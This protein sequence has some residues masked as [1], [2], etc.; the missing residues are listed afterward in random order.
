[1]DDE[2]DPDHE[3]VNSVL[4]QESSEL[5]R[6]LSCQ[7]P[8]V[9]ME[10]WEK[11][12][13]ASTAAPLCVEA[14]LEYFKEASAAKCRQFLQRVCL[15]CENM[16]MHL[17][18]RLMSVAGCAIS[19]CEDP[20]VPDRNASP[21]PLEQQL[22]KRPRIDHWEQNI[23]AV[24]RS[25]LTRFERLTQRLVREVQ[26]ENVWVG[27]RTANRGRDRPDQ[28][29]GSADRGSRTPEPD[30]YFGCLESRLTLESFF[31]GCVGKVTVLVGRAGSGKT[32]LMSCLGQQW[33]NGL[34]PI[35]SSYLFVLLEF[36]QLNLL[37]RPLTLSELLFQHHLPPA[38][39]D[40]EKRAVMDYLLSNP[41]QSCWVLDGYD[42]FHCK[43]GG[44][45][46]PLDSETPRPVADLVSGLL[47]RQL[48][49]GCTVLL[50]CRVRDVVDL[51]GVV[52]KVGQL[53]GWDQ[54][55]IEEYVDDF[56]GGKA[57]GVQAADLLRSSRHLLAMSSLPAL[58]NIC[59][60]CLEHLL[61]EGRDAG[62]TQEERGTAKAAETGGAGRDEDSRGR[63]RSLRG[64]GKREDTI[65]DG[66]NGGVH[67]PPSP[68]RLPST[69]TQVYLTALSAFLS[70]SP[71]EGGRD[72]RSTRFT[73][74]AASLG[75]YRSEL[76]EL[77]RLTWSGLEQSR[78][79][80]MEEDVPPGVL[81]F[82]LR[83]GLLSQ[84]EVRCQDGTP[85]NA[86]SFVH[87]TLQEFLAA[88]RIMTSNDVS[89]TQLRKR[90]SLKTRWMTK[91]DQRTVFT[92]SLYL[93]V[94]GLASP[95][96][97]AALVQLARASCGPG[98]QS[99][100]EKRQALVLKL[101]KGLCH[102]NNLTGPKLLE[103]CH[104]V[105]E[106][107]D[108]QLAKEVVGSRPVLELRKIW[109]LPND[110]DALAFV[111]NSGGDN[112]VGLDFGA[113]S[114]ELDCLDVLPRCQ[115]IH[116]LSFRS[117][118]YDDKFA[119]KLSSVLP[120]FA[121]LRKLEFFGT[122]L[123]AAGAASLASGLQNCL[124]ITEINL[125]DNNLKDEGIE[126]VAEIFNKL[127]TLA[128]V[129]LGRNNT[130]LKALDCLVEKMSSCSNI[131]HVHADGMKEVTVTFYTNHK[132][133][134]EPTI[135]LLNQKWSRSEM[136]KLAESLCRCPALSVLDLSGGQWDEEISK[137]LTQ[138]LPKFNVTEKIIMN[139]SCSSVDSLLLLTALL[140]DCRPV[141]ELHIRLQSPVQVSIL[142]SGGREKPAEETSRTLRLSCCNLLPAD[143]ERVWESLGTSSDLTVLDLSGNCLGN[144]GLRML[145]D[146]LPCLSKIQ[147]INAS[148][149]GTSPAGAALLAAALCSHDNL[150]Q[151]HISDGGKDQVILSFCPDGS[152]DKQQ[153]KTFRITN[154]SLR[155]SDVTTVC[156][157]LVR[158]R[159]RLEL[160]FSCSSLSHKAFE[161]LL[162]VLPK[163]TSL[164]RLDVSHSITSTADALTLVSCLTDS[165]RVSSVE[166][167][168]HSESFV[169]FDA[170]KPEEV[171]CRFTHFHLDGD[172]SKRLLE[173]LLQGPRLSDLNLSNNQL[174]DEGVKCVMDSLPTMKIRRYVNLSKNGLS[175]QGLLD[176]S[177][178]LRTCAHISAV[179]LSLD[180]EQKCLIWFRQS[181]GCEKTLSV[182]ESRLERHHLVG[183]AEIVS[184]CPGL[185]KVE[186]KNNSLQS[187][188]IEDFVKLLDCRQTGVIISVE[189]D[190]IRA[191]RAVRLVARCLDLNSNI[192]TISIHHSTLHLSLI[193]STQ[194]TPASGDSADSAPSLATK[195][196]GFVDC[197]DEHQL[198][199]MMSIIQR[200][201]SLTELHFSVTSF[202]AEGAEFLRSVLPSLPNLSS[203]SVGSKESTAAVVEH[204][205]EVLLQS[206]SIQHLNLSGH[207][208]RDAAARSLTRLLPRLRSVNLTRCVWSSAARL[209]LVEALGQCVGLEDLC[210]DS[211]L[212][213]ER[214]RT[215]LARAL[216]NLNSI[217]RLKLSK[218]ATA[219]G[220]SEANMDLLVAALEGLTQLEEIELD[221]WLMADG[222]IEQL[223]RLL[224]TWTEL[225]KISLSKNL[226]TDQSGVKL[227]E[228]LKSCSRLQELHL[229]SNSLCDLTAA[230]M[231]VVFPSLTHLAVFDI[232][233][234]RIGPEGAASLSK[235]I[236]CM[237]NLRKI[238][239]TSVG[240]SE[241]WAVAAGLAHCPLLQDVGLGWNNCGD[242]VALELARVLP[243][244][245]SLTRIDLE[246]NNVS[247]CGAEALLKALRSCPALHL[248]RLWR[249]KV[250]PSDAQRLHLVDRRL[251][252]SST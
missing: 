17:D 185:T 23:G 39:G 150:T 78:I 200:C 57:L 124:D 245:H 238:H 10:L 129:M 159:S 113:C 3:D 228:A 192:H 242:E 50:T 191:E 146:F 165:R 75:R 163:M 122:S 178:S 85:V 37:R 38:G 118:K 187:E 105:Q 204:V 69:L 137:T 15:L 61:R 190:W 249:N 88:L 30:G 111:V 123:T 91:A 183:F 198:A 174:G 5:L 114:M 135:S 107:Q 24:R 52:D 133:K 213:D 94:C 11:T 126:H 229:S 101:L 9:I 226:V 157:S 1:M 46:E 49:P 181:G 210:L 93:F 22:I 28:T 117:R 84:V 47:H 31:Q 232:S 218:V 102:S 27:L 142:F 217:R 156:R 235:A 186:F 222:G 197:V 153:L 168:P 177:R 216:R 136:Q 134:P 77:S 87:L 128:S 96:C 230:G 207:V 240:T 212:L 83:T 74:S 81:K 141:T 115:Y 139:D 67:P 205:S 171:S 147:T 109:L 208:I 224:P 73:H 82:S 170:V 14:M 66:T 152:E 209:Q 219:M 59:C 211:A 130:S 51:D 63:S 246:S 48:L 76:R 243:L 155:P 252:F 184:G 100:V 215:S 127:Q 132:S 140:S 86:Y 158:C 193:K 95:Q 90:F 225:R 18:S 233:E 116:Y 25:L 53:L 97:T 12:P 251:N 176:V 42:E 56:F 188:W 13:G 33:A 79:L 99:W 250:S 2:V 119:E 34:G 161:N 234:N 8:E 203:L 160:E 239:L 92:D 202:G 172:D 21:P 7:S 223:I 44:R 201:P 103:L 55:Q 206:A 40:D 149:N 169:S 151:I 112:G 214:S 4:A 241:L 179:E 121:T 45:E 16:P 196:I 98:V 36:R 173:T 220:Q 167:R 64:R 35:P 247:V 58:C 144:K 104:C 231:A 194:L 244:C 71:A 175:Q 62:G 148:N 189:E 43:L 19:C 68:T 20:G 60:I 80:F 29:P 70:R 41:A 248:I 164:Q 162:K 154:S 180:E 195:S 138:F 65:M 120:E 106:S 131:Q 182:R 6:V 72:D 237:K 32:L 89:D 166:L 227:L 221:G 110:I 54:H 143:L 125:S 108:Q 236:M 199:S 145:L 26:L